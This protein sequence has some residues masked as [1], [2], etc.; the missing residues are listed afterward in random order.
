MTPRQKRKISLG[1]RRA[2]RR[3]KRLVENGE[4]I[5]WFNTRRPRH[6]KRKAA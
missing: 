2:H 1:L 5:S 6:S 4:R 3:V